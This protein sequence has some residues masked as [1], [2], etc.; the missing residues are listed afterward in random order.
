M[1]AYF[2]VQIVIGKNITKNSCIGSQHC[3]FWADTTESGVLSL[4]IWHCGGMADTADL[5]SAVRNGVWVQVP[6]VLP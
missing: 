5:K 4:K 3:V 2:C 1:N 6:P